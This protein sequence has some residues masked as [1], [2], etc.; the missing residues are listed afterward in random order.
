M[1]SQKNFKEV[2]RYHDKDFPVNVY[3][4]DLHSMQPPGRWLHDFHWHEELQFTLVISGRLTMQA[5]GSTIHA[6]KG[7][8]I[9]INSTIIHAVTELSEDGEYASLNFPFR[10][11]SF[12]PGSRMDKDYVLPY[13]SGEKSSSLLIT[14]KEPWQEKISLLL[15][16]I[17]DYFISKQVRGHEYAICVMIVTMWNELIS[18]YKSEESNQ[19]VNVLHQQRLQNILSYIYEYY[20]ED[21]KL[22]DLANAGSISKAECCRIF[23]NILHTSPYSYLKNYRIQAS[24]A[25]LNSDMSISEIAGRVGYNQVSNYIASFKKIIGCTPAQYRKQEK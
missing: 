11:L 5:G 18:N 7:D 10:L 13:T 20:P 24:V 25:L 2:N 23:Q 15:R 1:K 8:L 22:K 21:I 19:S 17:T 16:E 14:P 12:F 9:F 3:Y 4:A 6:K